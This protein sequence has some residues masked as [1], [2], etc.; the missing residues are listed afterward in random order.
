[1]TVSG[2][3]QRN[4]AIPIH[5]SILPQTPLP[6]RLPHDIEQSSLCYTVG[7]CWLSISST[8]VCTCQSQ[9]PFLK[10]KLI[11]NVVLTSAIQQ[12]DSIIHTYILLN[13]IFHYSLSQ[14]TEYSSLCYTVRPCFIF[15]SSYL[16]MVLL[17]SLSPSVHCVH[18][19]FIQG[20]FSF[21]LHANVTLTP[22]SDL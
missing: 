11:Y 3:Q 12:N 21:L 19:P 8:A 10:L 20:T 9:A 4:S 2:G 15:C 17:I 18:S 5:V 6:S 13:I 7:Y 22:L 16:S 14:D 1:V